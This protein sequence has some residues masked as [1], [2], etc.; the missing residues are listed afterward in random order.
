MAVLC[1]RAGRLLNRRKRRF[2]ARAV[3]E[4]RR[5]VNLTGGYFVI[6]EAFEHPTFKTSLT[7]R[8]RPGRLSDFSVPQHFP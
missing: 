3:M 5:L 8:A 6:S 2:L 4:M 1:G 7:V